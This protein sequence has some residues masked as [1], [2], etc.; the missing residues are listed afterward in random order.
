MNSKKQKK[1][2]TEKKEEK[3]VDKKILHEARLCGVFLHW[4]I[5]SDLTTVIH[6]FVHDVILY[7][8]IARMLFPTGNN[9]RR[10]ILNLTVS[11]LRFR[12]TVKFKKLVQY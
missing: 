4:L 1:K 3:Q 6:C 8:R 7:T 12:W 5:S 2:R 9:A 10:I 11:Q